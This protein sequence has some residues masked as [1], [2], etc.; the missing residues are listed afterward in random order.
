ML[1]R[2]TQYQL[3]AVV[4]TRHSRARVTRHEEE[5]GRKGPLS[6]GWRPSV[7]QETDASA[8][9]AAAHHAAHERVDPVRVIRQVVLTKVSGK[10]EGQVQQLSLA[11]RVPQVETHATAGCVHASGQL[12]QD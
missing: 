10:R 4:P 6:L 11:D 8:L 1:R 7:E 12:I 3:N 2:E 9:F 5:T